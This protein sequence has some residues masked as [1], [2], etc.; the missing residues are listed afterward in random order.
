MLAHSFPHDWAFMFTY[1]KNVT[2]KKMMQGKGVGWG[3]GN[4]VH[5]P[6]KCQ[7]HAE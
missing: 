5:C 2:F 1:F 6:L 7:T 3:E 4:A